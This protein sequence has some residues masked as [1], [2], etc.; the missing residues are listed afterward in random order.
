MA[1]DAAHAT[2]ICTLRNNVGRLYGRASQFAVLGHIR[3]FHEYLRYAWRALNLAHVKRA[4]RSLAWNAK[5]TKNK[6]SSL[7]PSAD[8]VSLGKNLMARSANLKGG[9]PRLPLAQYREGSRIALL[10]LRPLHIRAFGSIHLQDHLLQ[11]GDVC[12]TCVHH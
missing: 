8:L 10:A 2:T 11:V 7:R 3:D 4:E 9:D 1:A 12:K 6:Q 5:P